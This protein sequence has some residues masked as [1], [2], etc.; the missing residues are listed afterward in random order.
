MVDAP[1]ARASGAFYSA[2]GSCS[3]ADGAARA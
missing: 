3:F 2:Q 1:G